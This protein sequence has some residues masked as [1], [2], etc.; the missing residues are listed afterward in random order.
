MS[1]ILTC[2][3]LTRSE[4]N[5]HRLKPCGLAGAR[6]D[7][8]ARQANQKDLAPHGVQASFS[9]VRDWHIKRG[10]MKVTQVLCDKHKRTVARQGREVLPA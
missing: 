2:E 8:F 7:V 5:K 3:T 4:T 9:A 1:E 10:T 6:Y